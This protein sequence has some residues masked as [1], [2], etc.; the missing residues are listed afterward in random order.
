MGGGGKQRPHPATAQ[1]HRSLDRQHLFLRAAGCHAAHAQAR[2]RNSRW[3]ERRVSR[4]RTGS[5]G[6]GPGAKATVS[7]G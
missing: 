4:V 6:C 3:A 5:A 1:A 2:P 7:A